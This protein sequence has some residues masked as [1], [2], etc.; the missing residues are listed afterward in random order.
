VP[1][2]QLIVC[3]NCAA[4]NRVPA[5][6]LDQGPR[7]GRCKGPLFDARPVALTD[8]TFDNFV[9]RTTIPV[10]VDCWA[11]WCGPCRQFAPVF[12]Q[13]TARLEPNVRL[14]KL[15]TESN[16]EVAHRLAIRSI[17]TLIAFRQGRELDRVS[18][19]LPLPQF[20]AWVARVAVA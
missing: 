12:E 9:T 6:R 16:T 11:A 7:C 18:G 15:D 4:A 5:D 2:P 14:A 1:E 17:P 20:L 13:A 10:V 19:A 3:P 8:A